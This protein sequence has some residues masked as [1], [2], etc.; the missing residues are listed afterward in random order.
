MITHWFVILYQ[1]ASGLYWTILLELLQSFISSSVISL[2]LLTCGVLPDTTPFAI[3]TALPIAP[4]LETA[5]VA[6]RPCTLMTPIRGSSGPP[7]CLPSPKSPS[8]AFKA[9]E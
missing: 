3:S 1:K 2:S 4:L 5:Y 6:V 9:G 7:S 8:H